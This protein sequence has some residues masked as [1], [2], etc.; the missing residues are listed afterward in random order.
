MRTYNRILSL[1]FLVATS[2]SCSKSTMPDNTDTEVIVDLDTRYILFD[3]GITTRGTLIQR[4][5]LDDNFNVL[6]YQYPG[7]WDVAS[8]LATP[9][10]FD[11]TPQLV[12]YS[13]GT[14]TY[15]PPKIWSGNTYSFFA[16][17]PSNNPSILLFEDG[18]VKPGTPYI[19]YKLA[20]SGNPRELVDIMT[21]SFVDTRIDYS[22]EVNLTMRHRLS[23]IDI[24]VRNYYIYNDEDVPQEVTI[25]L[26]KLE[27]RPIVAN[28]AVKIYL[29]N[30]IETVTA[31]GNTSNKEL[32]FSII[33]KS[34]SR[35]AWAYQTFEC[36]PNNSDDPYTFVTNSAK[37]D[38]TIQPDDNKAT[39]LILIPQKDRLKYSLVMEY[40]LRYGNSSYINAEKP[41]YQ[42]DPTVHRYTNDGTPL[43]FDNSLVEGR[44]YNIEITFTASA[45]SINITTSDEWDD[46]DD[47][48]LEFE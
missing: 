23:A 43:Y 20:T 8:V 7:L 41:Y 16:Y 3:A 22:P 2:L 36:A 11:S 18:N 9:N 40:R 10:V 38:D 25:E 27:F 19:T 13:D 24:V 12:E 26:T 37:H 4:Q 42:N 35:P 5:Y 21:G 1:L 47:V 33:D 39:S 34:S 17:Y 14:Y 46:K 44:R 6:G 29:D 28:T 31:E 48:K 32:T 45:V 15:D 30:K